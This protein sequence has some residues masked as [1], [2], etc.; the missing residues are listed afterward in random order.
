MYPERDRES[1]E[2]K[3]KTEASILAFGDVGRSLLGWSGEDDE[4]ATGYADGCLHWARR[5]GEG[6]FDL[7]IKEGVP[8]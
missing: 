5:R 1:S 6:R 4:G 3:E 7:N 2:L 8:S